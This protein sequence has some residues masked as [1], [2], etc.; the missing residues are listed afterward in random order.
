MYPAPR[1]QLFYRRSSSNVYRIFFWIVLILV[2]LGLIRG[3]NAGQVSSPFEPTPTPTRVAQ[4]YA[5]EG[6]TYFSAGNL[7]AA[8][9]SYGDAAR[10]DPNNGDVWA[11]LARI[12]VYSS[13]L[14]TTDAER[15]QRLAEALES[16]NQ[17]VAVAPD[18]SITHAVRAFVLDWN[19]SQA[20]VEGR[21]TEGQRMLAEA[22]QEAVRALQLDQTNTLA[23]AYYAE[24]LV[25]QQKWNQGEQ[26]I[27][28]AAERG[29]AL[30]DVHRV[31]AYVSESLGQYR[32]AI[33]E[34]DKAIA[35]TPNLTFLHIRAGAI[36]RHL[37][38]YDRALE[39][40]DRAAKIN[41]QNQVK[42][43]APYVSISKTYSQTGD[44][45]AAARN[46]Q[47]AITYNPS[48]AD[49]YG[50][51]GVIYFKSR[52]YEGSIPILACAI[53]GCTAQQTCEARYA[54][55][56]D[57]DYGE[58]GADITGL[59]LTSSTVVYYYTYGSVL[60]ALSRPQDNKCAEAVTILNQV[61]TTFADQPDIVRIAADG[62][63][64]CASLGQTQTTPAAAAI[65]VT[66]AP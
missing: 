64:I 51:L 52:N 10:V 45:F 35:I 31:Y 62:L 5:M 6:E 36:Y 2:S 59:P 37:K 56:C 16:A 60:A 26:Y 58:A 40:F 43:P 65:T 4:S 39:Y 22:E 18:D 57:P 23:L 12:Q 47:K 44:F 50:Q 15:R 54:R 29:E 61:S 9:Q 49:L 63:A 27:Q 1:R 28:Q 32:Q 42:N 38:D 53:Y 30:M 8:I 13:A 14:L 66:P 48:S 33:E 7:D 34:Y 24:I 41:A 20:F 3:V 25:D 17:A 46:I 11:K 19:A 21:N 55:D